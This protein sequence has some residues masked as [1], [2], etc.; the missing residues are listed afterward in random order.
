MFYIEDFCKL[1]LEQKVLIDNI[2]GINFPFYYDITSD[3]KRYG[4]SHTLMRRNEISYPAQGKISSTCYPECHT[5]FND[6]CASNGIDVDLILQAAINQSPYYHDKSCDIHV[7]HKIFDHYTFLLYLTDVTQGA[8]LLHDV[9]G[10]V[11]K[12]IK[13]EK[14][15]AV[16][17][18][19]LPHS[20]ETFDPKERRVT[21]IFTFTLKKIQEV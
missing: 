15:K 7:D 6:F 19:G 5:I 16:I 17:F 13:P 11:I 14:Y 18:S 3:D 4:F 8:T 2:L 10:G 21:M 12:R 9:N 1:T 20:V